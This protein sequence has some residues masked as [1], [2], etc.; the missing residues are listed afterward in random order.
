MKKFIGS[1]YSQ[2]NAKYGYITCII[3]GIGYRG[4]PTFKIRWLSHPNGLG[5]SEASQ[6]DFLRYFNK[7][8]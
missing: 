5:T 4:V 3:E 7:V 2:D 6:R 8:A 1:T